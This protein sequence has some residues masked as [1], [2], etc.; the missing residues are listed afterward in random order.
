MKVEGEAFNQKPT[1]I[2][3]NGPEIAQQLSSKCTGQHKHQQLMGGIAHKAEVYPPGFCQAVMKGIMNQMQKDGGWFLRKSSSQETHEV[4]VE[5]DE[6]DEDEIP[7]QDPQEVEAIGEEDEKESS[8]TISPEEKR[9]LDKLHRG[10]GH[11]PLNELI[12]FMKSARIKGEVVRWAAQ[13]YRCQVCESRPKP[14]AVRVGSI[15][16]TYQPNKVLGID[17]IT[18]PK[19]EERN[20]SQLCQCWTGAPTTRWS[21]YC[22]T[23][24]LTPSGK[25]CGPA[26]SAPSAHRRS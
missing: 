2:L 22:P 5:E 6:E 24:S 17:L 20:C 16:R 8:S 21:S 18:F 10:L 15:P 7:D 9:A 1:G 12:R 13:N 3:T 26:G 14:K 4:Y 11:P 19:W 25:P 23:K